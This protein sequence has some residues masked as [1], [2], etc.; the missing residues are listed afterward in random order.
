MGS[1]GLVISQNGKTTIT[2]GIPVK[3]AWVNM[4]AAITK[5]TVARGGVGSGSGRVRWSCRTGVSSLILGTGRVRSRCTLA[6]LPLLL[7]TVLPRTEVDI[8]GELKG[9]WIILKEMH[10]VI[11]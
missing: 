7:C 2:K 11:E 6:L 5:T 1:G 3:V 9:T 4:E 10:K 8:P